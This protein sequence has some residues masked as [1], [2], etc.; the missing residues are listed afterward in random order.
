MT[1]Q[2]QSTIFD[3]KLISEAKTHL[4]ATA[5]WAKFLAI[6]GFVCIVLLVI[7]GSYFAISEAGNDPEVRR[8]SKEAKIST[9]AMGAGMVIFYVI[10]GLLYF[11]PCLFLL[12]FSTK[13]KMALE[14]N[15]DLLLSESFRGLKK[16]FRYMGVL[17]LVF[18]GLSSLGVLGQLL[19]E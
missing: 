9:T 11:F 3:M 17:T 12:Q 1:E 4:D 18:I 5:K 7:G 19:G 14:S 10:F 2:S 16:T 8:A 15:D 6:C 13:M